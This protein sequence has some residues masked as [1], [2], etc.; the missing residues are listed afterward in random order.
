MCFYGIKVFVCD[1]CGE[2]LYS[3]TLKKR[4]CHKRSCNRV[5]P[6]GSRIRV[7]ER[8]EYDERHWCHFQLITASE[9]AKMYGNH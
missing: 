9:E 7:K 3:T 6:A 4:D 5:V 8:K 2:E 1:T